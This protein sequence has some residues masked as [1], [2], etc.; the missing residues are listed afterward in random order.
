MISINAPIS[1]FETGA[2]YAA[3]LAF[4]R[5]DRT[6][7]AQLCAE[8][9]ASVDSVLSSPAGRIDTS[10]DEV[11]A[12]A[13]AMLG[14][15]SWTWFLT[16]I[17][18]GVAGILLPRTPL[19]ELAVITIAA[20]LTALFAARQAAF[21][22]AKSAHERGRLTQRRSRWLRRWAGTAGLWILYAPGWLG[23]LVILQPW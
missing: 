12:D 2:Q 13:V 18:T 10:D 9:T 23:W 22:L 3:L 20:A 6:E 19:L 11:W 5:G 1:R 17:A 14:F 16:A 8:G 7:A 21:M 4:C 15:R